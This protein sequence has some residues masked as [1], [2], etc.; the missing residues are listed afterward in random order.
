M[1][2]DIQEMLNKTLARETALQMQKEFRKHLAEERQQTPDLDEQTAFEAWTIERLANYEVVLQQLFQ[3]MAEY[4]TRLKKTDI[5]LAEFQRN[6]LDLNDM[7]A[8]LAGDDD[9]Y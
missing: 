9:P 8:E 2:D 3:M 6:I 1:N 7:F 4:K 5:L